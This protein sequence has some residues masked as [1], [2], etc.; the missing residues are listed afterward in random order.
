MALAAG[1]FPLNMNPSDNLNTDNWQQ[2][3]GSSI[4]SCK[5]PRLFVFPLPTSRSLSRLL[6][7]TPFTPALS[8]CSEIPFALILVLIRK[9]LTHR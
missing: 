9:L 1:M 2:L 5:E 7:C 3:S 8:P 4:L 6:S